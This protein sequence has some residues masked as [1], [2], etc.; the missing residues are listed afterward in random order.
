MLHIAATDYF[1]TTRLVAF[2]AGAATLAAGLAL[3]AAG[4]GDAVGVAATFNAVRSSRRALISAPILSLRSVSF[5][6]FALILA[7]A[8]AAFETG[9]FLAATF[10]TGLAT[11]GEVLALGFTAA[12][13]A[14][15]F[16]VAI[17]EFLSI[18]NLH[19]I[20]RKPRIVAILRAH[21]AKFKKSA[22]TTVNAKSVWALN[23]RDT[24]HSYYEKN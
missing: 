13:V 5:A 8:L 2:F 15:F 12:L 21:F 6:I 17:F 10:T 7:I 11:F 19:K 18:F 24:C 22:A 3:V 23:M 1:L 20:L 14:T 16:A 4:A 9:A